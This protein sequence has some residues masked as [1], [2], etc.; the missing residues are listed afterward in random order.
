MPDHTKSWDRFSLTRYLNGE[1]FAHTVF[2]GFKQKRSAASAA[3]TIEERTEPH[4]FLK[5][6]TLKTDGVSFCFTNYDPSKENSEEKKLRPESGRVLVFA[7]QTP[8][9]PVSI[10]ISFVKDEGRGKQFVY[11][12][13]GTFP[14]EKL[15]ELRIEI[16]PAFF[17]KGKVVQQLNRSISISRLKHFQTTLVTHPLSASGVSHVNPRLFPL[18]QSELSKGALLEVILREF[19]RLVYPSQGKA[20]LAVD[21][22]GNYWVASKAAPHYQRMLTYLEARGCTGGSSLQERLSRQGKLLEEIRDGR[23]VGFGRLVTVAMFLDEKDLH[24][25]NIGIAGEHI[26]SHDFDFCFLSLYS[27]SYLLCPITLEMINNLPHPPPGVFN[28]LDTVKGDRRESCDSFPLDTLKDDP[29]IRREINETILNILL[30]PDRVMCELVKHYAVGVNDAFGEKVFV[31][32]QKRK[33]ELRRVSMRMR[34]FQDYLKGQE[35]TEQLATYRDYV[36]HFYLTGKNQF[37]QTDLQT[38]IE[39]EFQELVEMPPTYEHKV[40]AR[41]C[42]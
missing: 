14:A 16:D 11:E 25:G 1:S 33:D 12:E 15:S 13:V 5:E 30:L 9:S 10:F 40:A 6:G 41:G 23:C 27:E 21:G 24:M 2:F 31:A 35:V 17:S 34:S 37:D 32:L 38:D 8:Y 20:R 39:K 28:W 36:A 7:Q 22:E 3:S 19:A 4:W 42:C 29:L 26:I 18:L